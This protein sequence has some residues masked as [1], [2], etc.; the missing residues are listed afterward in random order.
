[1]RKLKLQDEY[2]KGNRR[3][4]ISNMNQ[5][6]PSYIVHYLEPIRRGSTVLL[7]LQSHK[8]LIMDNEIE[9]QGPVISS[10]ATVEKCMSERNTELNVQIRRYS[11]R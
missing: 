4:Y 10:S 3:S 7:L 6:L 8:R 11:C 9:S 1:M 2:R 5:D